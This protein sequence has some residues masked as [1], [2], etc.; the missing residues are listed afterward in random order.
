MSTLE[1]AIT[2][3]EDMP[4][5]TVETVYAF[6]LSIHT[7]ESSSPDNT[8]SMDGLRLLQSYAGTLSE[9]FDYKT[10]LEEAREKKYGYNKSTF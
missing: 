8:K 6:M 1:K 4:E 9:D 2:L 5:Q 10:A 3:L 7:K